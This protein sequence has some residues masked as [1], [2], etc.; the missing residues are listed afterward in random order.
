M[1]PDIFLVF[2]FLPRGD[3][4][5]GVSGQHTVGRAFRLPAS[6]GSGGCEG[7]EVKMR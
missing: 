7:D 3:S 6:D 2:S 1:I 5:F 4:G